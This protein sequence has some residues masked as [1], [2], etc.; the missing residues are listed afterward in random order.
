MFWK[1][2]KKPF[3]VLA[4]MHEVTDAA[5]RRVVA[6][7][8][9]PDVIFTEFVSVDGLCHPKSQKKITEYY[10]K[11]SESERPVV[12]QIWGSN[13]DNFLKAAEYVSSLGFDG[14]DINMGCPDKSVVKQGGGAAMIKTP[15]LAIEVIKAAKEGAG[16]LPVSVKTRIGFDEIETESWITH[17]I[18]AKPAV[19]TIHGRTKKELSRVPTHWDQI[20]LAASMAK[21]SEIKII[22]NGDVLSLDEGKKLSEKYDLDGIMVGRAVMGNPWFFNSDIKYE[23]ISVD[24]KIEAMLFHAKIFEEVFVGVKRFNHFKKHIKAYISG[25]RN[26]GELRGK[27]MNAKHFEEMKSITDIKL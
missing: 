22:G 12:A 13:P 27:L 25:F 1:N 2:L 4:P 9:K 11:Y 6:H 8:G 19:I 24:Q 18:N 5:F 10:L 14:I 16:N 26:A 17:L 7:Y 20:A 3:F 15:D 21:G 23:N